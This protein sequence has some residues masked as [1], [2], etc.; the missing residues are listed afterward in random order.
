MQG[1]PVELLVY[2]LIFAGIVVFN[3]L[4]QRLARRAQQ[5]MPSPTLP[6]PEDEEAEQ[7][8]DTAWGRRPEAEALPEE[9]AAA[10]RAAPARR[11]AAARTEQRRQTRVLFRTRDDVRRAIV[12]MTVLGPCRALEPPDRR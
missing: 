5:R 9:V 4:V 7:P 6:M 8:P 2:A 10:R 12:A 3:Y 11:P 1:F